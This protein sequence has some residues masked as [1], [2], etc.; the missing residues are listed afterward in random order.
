MAIEATLMAIAIDTKF[1]D[2]AI[3]TIATTEIGIWRQTRE[4][5]QNEAVETIGAA[6]LNTH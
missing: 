3:E 1:S 6:N 2:K 4:M 5:R